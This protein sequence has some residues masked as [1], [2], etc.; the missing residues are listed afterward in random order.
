MRYLPW[1]SSDLVADYVGV[2]AIMGLEGK[3]PRR[4]GQLSGFIYDL[5]FGFPW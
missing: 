2:F 4:V 5:I 3:Y 1:E